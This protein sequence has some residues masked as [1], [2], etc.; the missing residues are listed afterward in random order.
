MEIILLE[1][2]ANLGFKDEV[3]TVKP[4]FA[5][6]FLIPNKKAIYA[7]NSRKKQLLEN[8]KQKENKNQEIIK[9]AQKT[10]STP[11]SSFNSVYGTAGATTSI[12]NVTQ[13][14]PFKARVKYFNQL[15]LMKYP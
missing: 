15:H 8:S 14:G 10:V 2:I 4:G 11:S 9:E 12:V 1:D 5:R 6:N 13:S 3:V 7:T